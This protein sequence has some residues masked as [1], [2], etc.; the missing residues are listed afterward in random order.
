MRPIPKGLQLG[1][2]EPKAAIAAFDRRDLLLPSFRSDD[3]WQ[4][5]HARGFASAGVMQRDVLQL[6]Y[7]ETGAALQQGT[8]F[9][10]YAKRVREQLVA[11][12]FWGDVEVT[13]PTTGEM[14]T[15]RFN[16]A[17]LRLI[18]DTN[19]GA[20]YTAGKWERY[21][22]NKRLFPFLQY[23]TKRDERVRV[24]HQAWDNVVLPIDHPWWDLHLPR[25]AW[26]CRCDF[27]QLNQRQ[28]DALKRAGIKIKTEPP[29]DAMKDMTDLRTGETVRIPV[30]V[31]P[32]FAYHTG[33]RPLRGAVPPALQADPFERT[34]S[35]MPSPAAPFPRN[36]PASTLLVSR[37]TP[38]QAAAAFLGEFKALAG[39]VITTDAAGQTMVIDA[40]M[41]RTLSGDWSFP[42][43]QRA[44]ARLLARALQQPDEIWE[45]PTLNALRGT[46]ALRRRYV[47]RMVIEGQA[48][49]VV[50]VVETGRDGVLTFVNQAEGADQ[51]AFLAAMR[52]GRRVYVRADQ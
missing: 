14:R 26:R 49:P 45:A 12:G 36:T 35:L 4:Q 34:P 46:S 30:G 22:R 9:G 25:K 6:L 23:I 27:A 41:L 1:V 13:D 33:R 3:V 44:F 2:V 18:F 20:S 11:K 24:T 8:S 43:A 51:A 15:T 50:I 5:E 29:V 32:A 37:A 52:A 38:D 31:D 40:E 42:D 10:D 21:Q 7:D 28:V 16:D 19:L 48:Q 17:R 39:P 47:L